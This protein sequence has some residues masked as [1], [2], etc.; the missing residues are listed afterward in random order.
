[1]KPSVRAKC[2]P[3]RIVENKNITNNL[4]DNLEVTGVKATRNY[5]NSVDFSKKSIING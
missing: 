5:Y 1:M 3:L 4:W 2:S